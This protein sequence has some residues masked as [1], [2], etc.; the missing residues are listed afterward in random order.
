[1]TARIKSVERAVIDR[2]DRT[3]SRLHSAGFEN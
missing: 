3:N 1:M 2:T